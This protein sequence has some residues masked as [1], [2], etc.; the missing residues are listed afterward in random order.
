MACD[1][2]LAGQL[3]GKITY[4]LSKLWQSDLVFDLWP[5]FI[6]RSVH[7]GLQVYTYSGYDLSYPG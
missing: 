5:E 4:K 2:Q 1:A 7:T 6:S 3:Y